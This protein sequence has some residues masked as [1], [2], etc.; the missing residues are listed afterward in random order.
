MS[1]TAKTTPFLMPKWGMAVTEA[2]IVKWHKAEGE[3]INKGEV[4][5]DI[6]TAK[7]LEEVESPISGT[8][9]KILLAEGEEAEV[10][11]EIALIEASDD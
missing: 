2:T 6:E 11:S 3:R 10:H 1:T 8:V 4:L 9:K 5:V 7:A